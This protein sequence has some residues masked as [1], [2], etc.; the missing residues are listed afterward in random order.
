M[1][2]VQATLI[3]ALFITI[4][5]KKESTTIVSN[6][7]DSS[8]VV[9]NLE[10]N[11][12]QANL[13]LTTLPESNADLGESPYYTLPAWLDGSS[14]YGS[15][16]KTDY[17]KI[18]LYTGKDFYTVEGPVNTK[19]FEMRDP[20]DPSNREWNEYKYVRSFS[21]HFESLGAKKI[22]EGKIPKEAIENLNK[23]NNRDDYFYNFGTSQQENI[24]VYGLKKTGKNIFFII[25]S[26]SAFGSITVVENGELKQDIGIIKSDQIQKDLTEKGKSILH[27]NFDTDK[28]SLKTD[29]KDAVAEI[30]KVLKNDKTIKL[31]INGYTDNSGNDTHNQQLSKD[32]ATT[33]LNTLVTS[34]IDKS[35]LT[36]NGFGSKNPLTANTTEEG[37]SKN[38]RVELVKK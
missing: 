11:V 3:A 16:K 6:S 18:E 28:A 17:G 34:G 36:S 2:I 20:N 10:N 19:N 14:T 38:R 21:K 1:K 29:G 8:S 4:S 22:W 33:V 23:K 15:D 5:C 37:K 27:I 31:E 30:A 7:Q 25:G 26:D 24:I 32:R 35:R 12:N 13:D 9:P